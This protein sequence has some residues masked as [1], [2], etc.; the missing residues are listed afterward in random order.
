[1]G[2]TAVSLMIVRACPH[3]SRPPGVVRAHP[4]QVQTGLAGSPHDFRT[5][6]P[7]ARATS[8]D[9]RAPARAQAMLESAK[10]ASSPAALHALTAGGLD[11]AGS[12]W[13]AVT[14][15]RAVPL[16]KQPAAAALHAEAFCI[17]GKAWEGKDQHRVLLAAA[18]KGA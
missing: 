2:R 3:D 18:C 16:R 10:F 14:G 17:A 5:G 15:R 8:S 13:Q 11:F 1:M 6:R 12:A 4:S 7:A 9:L